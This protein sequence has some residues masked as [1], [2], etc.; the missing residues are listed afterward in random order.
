MGDIYDEASAWFEANFDEGL[1]VGTWWERLAASGWGFPDWPTAWFGRG[2]AAADAAEVERARSAVGA[3]GP[4]GGIGA[5]LVAPTLFVHGPE[6]LLHRYLPAIAR[7]EEVWCQ[8]FSEPGAG[9]DLAGLHTRAERDGDDWVV[10]G[11]KVWT[12]GAH[13][14]ARAVLMA[15]TDPTVAK[16][17]GITFFAVDLRQAGVEVRPLR[18]MT[19]DA[20]FNEVFLSDVRVAG[21]DVIGEVGGGWA[22]AMT[23]LGIE[24]DLDAIGHDGGGD[25]LGDVDLSTTVAELSAAQATGG[26]GTNSGFAYATGARKDRVVADL[27]AR[28]GDTADPR[29]RQRLAAAAT[30]RRVLDWDAARAAPPSLGKVLNSQLCRRL[31]DLGFEAAGG[32]SLLTGPDAPDGGHFAKFALFTQGMSLAG[33]S[34]EI[35]RNILGERVLGLPREPPAPGG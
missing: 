14:A 29:L 5:T 30:H 24:R 9:S 10:N 12:S 20:E 25:A 27:V 33:G 21:D 3:F 4:P 6:T 15:R 2:L 17:R 13:L 35:Q 11:Q 1:T 34:D 32:R 28:H 19:G 8:L 23:M 7:G 22:V 31:R 26:Q 16:H 18:D